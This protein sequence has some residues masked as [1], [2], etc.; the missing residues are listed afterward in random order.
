MRELERERKKIIKRVIKGLHVEF[1]R[2]GR[3]A[4]RTLATHSTQTLE[5]QALVI[6]R[7][8]DYVNRCGTTHHTQA[9]HVCVEYRRQTG[10]LI[11]GQL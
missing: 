3:S 11:V 4:Y 9:L 10:Q 7:E 2:N 5:T 1:L 6:T 8:N